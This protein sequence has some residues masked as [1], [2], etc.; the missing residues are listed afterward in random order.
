MNEPRRLGIVPTL[1]LIAMLVGGPDDLRATVSRAMAPTQ[2][3]VWVR[4]SDR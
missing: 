4:G 2:L 3:G 1:G